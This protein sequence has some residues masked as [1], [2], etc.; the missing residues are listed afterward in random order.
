MIAVSLTVKGQDTWYG[1]IALYGGGGT[2]DIFREYR[3][4]TGPEI[5]E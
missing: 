2:N 3:V 5:S 1:E 4:M